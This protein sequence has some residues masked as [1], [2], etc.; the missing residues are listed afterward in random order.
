MT[1]LIDDDIAR[2]DLED[3]LAAIDSDRR[4]YALRYRRE[5]DRRQCVA[6]WLLLRE[7]LRR[8][9]GITEPPLLRYDDRGKPRLAHY[10]AIHFNLSHCSAAAACA[11]SDAPVG[12]DIETIQPIDDDLLAHTMSAAE[13][14]A[15]AAAPSAA[16]EFTRLWT[17]KESLLKLTGEGLRDDMRDVLG[18][19]PAGATF[20]TTTLASHICTVACIAPSP[21]KSEIEAAFT[22]WHIVQ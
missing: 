4:A 14:E 20:A 6:A 3:A 13:R 21:D 19:L 7:A 22:V 11:V 15:I 1:V 9:F 16:V 8:E 18:P 10:P 2:L 17:M 5:S 12:I